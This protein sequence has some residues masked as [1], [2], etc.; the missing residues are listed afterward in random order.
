METTNNEKKNARLCKSSEIRRDKQHMTQE[1]LK[2]RFKKHE[3]KNLKAVY[4]LSADAIAVEETMN[5]C[6]AKLNFMAEQGITE[7]SDENE[8][9]VILNRIRAETRVV[10]ALSHE[11]CKALQKIAVP[12]EET[13][14]ESP[15][16][17]ST[18]NSPSY[19]DD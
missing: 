16:E 8:E 17:E 12:I 18:Q 15:N 13:H 5:R 14:E 7:A 9:A 11:L 3:N 10:E 4:F 19:E 6:M 2:E 1:E